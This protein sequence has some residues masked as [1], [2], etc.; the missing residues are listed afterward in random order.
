MSARAVSVCLLA[1]TASFGLACGFLGRAEESDTDVEFVLPAE[2]GDYIACLTEAD[3]DLL[4]EALE[5]FGV[6]GDCWEEEAAE[7]EACVAE[8]ADGLHDMANA[9]P[10]STACRACPF[11][12]GAYAASYVASSSCGGGDN[13][14]GTAEVTCTG[15]ERFEMTVLWYD[16]EAWAEDLDCTFEGNAF[17]C[18]MEGGFVVVGDFQGTFVGSQTLEGEGAEQSGDCDVSWAF[19]ATYAG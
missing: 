8:C 4:E 11:V 3:T 15:A 1:C 16:D 12:D 17:D 7:Q 10:S 14:S 5:D 2:C 13:V 19:E 18:T 9:H 6:E